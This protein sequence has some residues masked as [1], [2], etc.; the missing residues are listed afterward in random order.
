MHRN[1]TQTLVLREIKLV[2]TCC[3]ASGVMDKVIEALSTGALSVTGLV[4]KGESLA[5]QLGQGNVAQELMHALFSM[6]LLA[7]LPLEDLVKNGLVTMRGNAQ[8]IKTLIELHK[9][10]GHNAGTVK[11]S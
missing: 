4:T 9:Q 6:Y 2:G 1:E 8:E 11:P 7:V 10:P 3:F 5:L